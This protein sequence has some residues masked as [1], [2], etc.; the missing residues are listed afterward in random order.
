M[1]EQANKIKKGR[2]VFKESKNNTIDV[3]CSADYFQ[4]GHPNISQ[5]LDPSP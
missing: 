4:I 5:G 3:F 1:V 2:E